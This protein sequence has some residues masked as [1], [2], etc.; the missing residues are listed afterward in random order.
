MPGGS[1]ELF[2]L[3]CFLISL[4]TVGLGILSIWS[5]NTEN[6]DIAY[7]KT[8]HGCKGNIHAAPRPIS[9]YEVDV[10]DYIKLS[11][12]CLQ[13]T[14]VTEKLFTEADQNSKLKLDTKITEES[15]L[16]FDHSLPNTWQKWSLLIAK[17]IDKTPSITIS[18]KALPDWFKMEISAHKNIAE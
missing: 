15:S 3:Y 16:Y 12:N 1:C 4:H 13:V 8:T 18:V 6:I 7:L 10:W 2:N 11:V 17:P 9:P 14:K 5:T